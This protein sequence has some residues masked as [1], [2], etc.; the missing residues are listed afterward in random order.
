MLCSAGYGATF[1]LTDHFR[2]FGGNE[3]QT[4]WTLA[5][6]A[7]G[8]L[9]GVPAVGWLA[10][11]HGPVALASLGSL[12]LAIGFALLA[13]L[14]SLSFVTVICGVLI[15]LGWGA[16]FL[17]APMS[18]SERVNDT[19]RISWFMW[20]GA[21]QMTAIGGGP[22]I[23]NLLRA[24]YGFTTGTVFASIAVCA[25]FAA[26][27]CGI[28][29]VLF[30]RPAQSI[31]PAGNW[32]RSLGP[33]SQTSS[34]YPIMMVFL[35]AC[36]FTSLLTFQSSI[37]KTAGFDPSLFYLAYTATVVVGRFTLAP[38]ASR[39]QPDLAAIVL[40]TIMSMGVAIALMQGTS[41]VMFVSAAICLG[42]GYGLVYSVIQTQVVNDAPIEHRGAALTWFVLAY[43]AGV[44]GFPIVGGWIIV[45]FGT[46][47]LL[48]TL[49]ALALLEL[50]LAVWAKQARA[51]LAQQ[52]P[53][54]S[55][56]R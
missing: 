32:L 50:A 12:I 1:L 24:R 51:H 25:A 23:L 11:R 39:S 33:L 41:L 5:G 6:A 9:I 8:T 4:G 47:F 52:V 13:A 19:N 29:G 3:I 34:I 17:S 48:W 15:G 55:V 54:S 26:C 30:A 56:L 40:L 22:I 45:G 28:F 44:F 10:P 37:A 53:K 27:L 38:I 18:L 42:I 21:A 36:I 7:A 16:F 46:N 14:E 20:L 43:F 49:L 31:K 2:Q 35:G